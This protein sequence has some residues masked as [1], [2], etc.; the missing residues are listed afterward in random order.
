MLSG[1]PPALRPLPAPGLE[2]APAKASD[3]LY[4]AGARAPGPNEAINYGRPR[5]RAKKPALSPAINPGPKGARQP[6]PPLEPY[7]TSAEARRRARLSPTNPADERLLAQ[8]PGVAVSQASQPT[9]A[10]PKRAPEADPYAPLGVEAGGLRLYPYLDA[11]GGYDSNP[12]RVNKPSR[13]SKLVH[14][15]AGTRIQS[16]W[17]RHALSGSLRMGYYNFPD[18]KGANRPEGRGA[19]DGRIDVTRDTQIDVGGAFSIDTIRT[20]S[21]EL[22][23]NA[24]TTAV[25]KSRPTTWSLGGYLGAT[26]RFNRLEVSLRGT[27]ERTETGDVAYSDGT[28]Q[29]LS[30]NNYTTIGGKSR[31]SYEASPSFKPFV[32]ATLDKR[33]YDSARDV[34]GFARTSTGGAV[35]AGASIDILNELRGEVA[36]GYAER[37]YE[38]W[39]LAPLRGPSIDAALIWDASPLTT[40]TLR[41]GTSLGETT[42]AN[43]SGVKTR[44]IEAEI[45][46][47]L[48]R[49]L[50]LTGNVG[51]SIGSY[52]GE[53]MAPVS[54]LQPSQ[55]LNQRRLTAGVRATYNLTRTIALRASYQHERLKSTAQ[56]ADYTANVFLVGLRLQR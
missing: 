49:N 16:E 7:R 41:G 5:K 38:D 35:R 48:L 46:H 30:L 50:I 2:S 17:S 15:E 42:I 23:F 11:E 47:A 10:K 36:G 9:P 56:N 34:N 33:V 52:Q 21:P 12:N 3:A 45:S 55:G 44:K 54:T 31:I 4:S 25:A 6:G 27:I 19:L 51:Y 8:R 53:N 1:G 37:H 39:R 13:G 29:R 20:G 28:T 22:T 32:E 24:P 26:Q 43:A 18:V 40:I 14:G